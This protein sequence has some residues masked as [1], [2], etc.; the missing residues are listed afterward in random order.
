[1]A[2]EEYDLVAFSNASAAADSRKALEEAGLK[3]YVMPTPRMI[4]VSCGLSL[5]L[6]AEQ[7]QQVRDR[8]NALGI[9]AEERHF[10]HIKHRNGCQT[11]QCLDK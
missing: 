7:C 4:S 5:R 1:M 3:V 9:P 2:L 10:Y 8:L 11:A 6:P